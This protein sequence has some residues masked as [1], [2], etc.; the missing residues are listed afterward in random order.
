V[1]IK[2]TV[3]APY[4]G[5]RES[6][7]SRSGGN[8]WSH[9]RGVI[10]SPAAEPPPPADLTLTNV[11]LSYT[12]AGWGFKVSGNGIPMISFGDSILANGFNTVQGIDVNGEWTIDQTGTSNYPE[13][14]FFFS[15]PQLRSAIG[16]FSSSR[17]SEFGSSGTVLVYDNA[18][19]FFMSNGDFNPGQLEEATSLW[20]GR[21]YLIGPSINLQNAI[22]HGSSWQ[23][24]VNNFSTTYP[25]TVEYIEIDN[26]FVITPTAPMSA[27]FNAT[28]TGS[29][30]NISFITVNESA[31]IIIINAYPQ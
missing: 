22:S 10:G 26:R 3:L 17:A 9:G 30:W 13:N 1:E 14:N 11:S 25:A 24:K 27:E 18:Q 29:Y 2:R 19:S 4:G 7:G 6:M 8:A 31:G 16:S 20:A 15:S 12:V 5:P 23:I 28:I 21:I